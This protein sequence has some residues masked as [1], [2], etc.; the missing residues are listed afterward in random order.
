M[1]L[2]KFIIKNIHKRTHAHMHTRPQ[3]HTHAHTHTHT[4]TNAHT[5]TRTNAHTRTQRYIWVL[6]RDLLKVR[7]QHTFKHVIFNRTG[8][9]CWFALRGFSAVAFQTCWLVLELTGYQSSSSTALS[10]I[11]IPVFL[12]ELFNAKQTRASRRA[13]VVAL[14]WRGRKLI[15]INKLKTRLSE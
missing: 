15:K 12:V 10:A 8:R 7:F 3:A 5:H 6:L 2:V 1:R 9:R 4:R 14:V 13:L 11:T